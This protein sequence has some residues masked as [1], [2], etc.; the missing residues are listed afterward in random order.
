MTS[1]SSNSPWMRR[2]GADG[3]MREI[4]RSMSGAQQPNLGLWN[5]PTR[6]W[7]APPQIAHIPSNPNRNWGANPALNQRLA[8]QSGYQGDFGSGGYQ[9]F[10]QSRQ[11]GPSG[12][13]GVA[14]VGGGY[15]AGGGNDWVNNG[16]NSPRARGASIGRPPLPGT[17]MPGA[18]APRGGGGTGINPRFPVTPYVPQA[19]A[20]NLAPGPN[21]I[22]MM[23]SWYGKQS[24]NVTNPDVVVPV[25][26]SPP[27]PPPS[28][29]DGGGGGQGGGGG[30]AANGGRPW[31]RPLRRADG[32]DGGND[33]YD[34]WN[35]YYDS[36]GGGYEGG[37]QQANQRGDRTDMGG[38]AGFAGIGQPGLASTT[39]N[40][41]QGLMAGL[42]N[43]AEYG[44]YDDTIGDYTGMAGM[45][46]ATRADESGFAADNAGMGGT[47]GMGADPDAGGNGMGGNYA[48]GGRYTRK[49]L[50]PI[51]AANGVGLGAMVDGGGDGR[52]DSVPAEL[53]VDEFV[54][55]ADV[56]AA[57]G[58]GSSRAGAQVLAK[59]V[60]DTRRK[61]RRKLGGLPG[62]KV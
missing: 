25:P 11:G 21:D 19:P 31:R 52:S 54:M 3:M 4:M 15:G 2:G 28:V 49:P 27:A 61:W 53:S 43:M 1:I 42:T 36:L 48:D 18:G 46:A 12:P 16:P 23:T 51:R 33:Y 57:K 7:D 29:G 9:R 50:R 44:P 20:P 39:G 6:N 34:P 41:V 45:P 32:G 38:L 55:P 26:P 62:P 37:G 24:P 17:V 59:D 58:N 30:G 22:D 56:V 8:A 60:V 13:F 40:M 35:G 10:M 5:P 14:S 47:S